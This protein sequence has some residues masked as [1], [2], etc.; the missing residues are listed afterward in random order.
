M[1][2]NPQNPLSWGEGAPPLWG[3]PE[4]LAADPRAYAAA[5]IVHVQ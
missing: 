2:A 4:D 5:G 1:P 3:T